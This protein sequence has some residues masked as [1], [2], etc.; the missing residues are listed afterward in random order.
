MRNSTLRARLATSVAAAVLSLFAAGVGAPAAHAE[1]VVDIQDAQ[2]TGTKEAMAYSNFSLSLSFPRDS[3]PKSLQLDLPKGQLGVLSA[4][5]ICP[6]ATF[7]ADNCT[8][9]SQIGNTT[10]VV[11]TTVIGN[12]TATGAIFRIPTTGSEVGRLGIVVRPPIGD[13]MFLQGLMRVRDDGSYGIRAIVPDMPKTAKLTVI[14]GLPPVPLD[15]TLESMQMTMFGRIGGTGTAGFFFNPAECIPAVTAV[16]STAWDA[17]VASDTFSYTPT[18]C[19]AVPFTPS[20]VFRPNPAPA[21]APAE[22]SVVVTTPFDGTAAKVQAPMRNTTIILPPGVQL[23]GATN[24]DGNLTDCTDAQFSYANLAPSSC[25][26]GSK[27]GTVVMD[28]PLVGEVPG[29]VYVAKPSPGSG[30]I[31]RLFVTAQLGT[32]VDAVRVKLLIRVAV[33]PDTGKMT[34]TLVDLPAQPVKSFAFTFRGG[35][36]P[37]TRS[38][39]LCGTYTGSAEITP[40]SS[41]TPVTRNSDYVV[42]T[43]CPTPGT[44]RPALTMTTSPTTAGAATTGTTTITLPIGDE[45]MT[46]TKVSL[47]PGML[48]NLTGVTLCTRAQVGAGSCP[49]A[50]KVG[51]VSS[52]A[53]QSTKPGLFEGTVYLTQPPNGS[54]LAGLFIQVPVT[55]GPIYLDDLKIEAGLSLRPDYGVDVISAIPETVRGLQLDQQELKLVF[56][57][58]NFL[59]NPPV[60]TGNTVQGAFTSANGTK[61]STSSPL[62]VTGCDAMK[63]EPSIAFA[64]TPA[65]ATAAAGLTTTVSFPASVPGSVQAPAKQIT[66]TLPEG[67]ALSPSAGARG[68][69]AGC[70]DAQ[71]SAGDLAAPTCPAGSEVGTTS[72]QT[73][74]VGALTGKAYLG[75]TVPGHLARVMIDATSD[76]YGPNARVKLVGFIDVDEATGKTTATFEGLPPVGFTEFKLAM[77]G[78]DA[79]VLAMPRTCGAHVGSAV[80]TPYAGGGADATPSA[81]LTIDQDCPDP[82]AFA[83]TVELATSTT[84]AGADTALTTVVKVPAGHQALTALSLTMPRGLLGRLTAVPLCPV[85]RAAAGT[86]DEASLVGTV[87]AKA[88]VASAPFSVQGRVYMTAGSG[89]AIAGLAFVLPAVV[90]P[91]DLGNVVTLSQ[92]K[93]GGPD[94]TLQITADAIPTQVKGIPLTL[95]ELAIAI[96]KPGVVLNAST[97]DARA[98]TAI[99]SGAGGA[100]ASASAPY[101]A[102]GCGGLN[103]RPTMQLD[104]TGSPAE[105]AVKGHPTVVTE[106]TQTEGQGN[107]RG[108]QVLLPAGV[109]TDLRNINARSCA[110]VE[111]AAAGGCPANA[112]VGSAT[113]ITSALPE[114]VDAPIL[115]VKVAGQV[116]PG[117]LLQVRDQIS[118]DQ[119]GVTKIDPSGRI[120]VTFDNLPDTP[121]SKMSLTFT[122]GPEGVIQI[123]K[124]ICAAGASNATLTAQHGAQVPFA[125]PVRCNG[126]AASFGSATTVPASAT[127]A[128]RPTG[129]KRGYTLTVRNAGGVRRLALGMPK[130]FSYRKGAKARNAIK[131][132]LTGGSGSKKVKVTRSIKGRTLTVKIGSAKVTR[133]VVTVSSKS[134]KF[135]AKYAKTLRKRSGQKKL[136]PR[137]SILDD[138]AKPFKPTAK[139]SFTLAKK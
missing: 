135:T 121:I 127:L 134:A 87:N 130:G 27:V 128:V 90:G 18:N 112:T 65:S 133:V 51:T 8:S 46:Q 122:G 59:T 35:D 97:C 53:G 92:L 71:F 47:P 94:L 55:V 137:L 80:M 10:V 118:F 89:D 66:L 58:A 20:V 114:P 113:I 15:I 111:V 119:L 76:T 52:L 31:I 82:A 105:V 136:K 67:V 99:L 120:A 98:A 131:V 7:E 39:R 75:T 2:P 115:L 79:P 6:L 72:I 37:G 123:G 14:P 70:S 83:P 108:A 12:I 33:D 54:S 50:S 96:D 28:S 11:K 117:L 61:A 38:P 101:Q 60:C 73:P 4:A 24:S 48:A 124:D 30:D 23:T 45:P 138:A 21:S 104:F 16:S 19:G 116:L 139:V 62:S 126:K 91:I 102:T 86:C 9:A 32:A 85:D 93:I 56:D 132:R 3:T 88:G 77:R 29:E 100:T 63:F 110:S 57:R 1:F 74:S 41:S 22:F 103:W 5:S 78:G 49:A 129:K 25:P 40:F 17:S 125:L 26:A 43:N 69:L 64:A 109:A 68:D 106:I 81:A 36:S 44:F 34:N 107:L 84:Q 42:S 13:K 95:S